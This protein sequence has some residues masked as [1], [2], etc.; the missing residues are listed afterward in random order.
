[1][2]RPLTRVRVS[3]HLVIDQVD[4]NGIFVASL[5]GELD[6][7]SAAAF[8]AYLNEIASG[9][10]RVVV[11]DLAGLEFLNATGLSALLEGAD[12]IEANGGRFSVKGATGTAQKVLS[13]ARPDLTS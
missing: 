10:R 2:T 11:V 8:A 13:L 9:G 1:M 3:K 12:T 6:L 7:S 5:I 4:L